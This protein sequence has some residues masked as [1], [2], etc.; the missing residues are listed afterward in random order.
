MIVSVNTPRGTWSLRLDH[1]A[2]TATVLSF[3][4]SAEH[5]S[6]LAKA[7]SWAKAEASLLTSGPLTDEQY[8]ARIAVCRACEHLNA[9]PA[10]LVGHCKVCGC[11]NNARA[12]LTVKGRMPAATCPK[13][14]WPALT[15][16]GGI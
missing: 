6:M 2:Q 8:E 11:N 13:G 5:Q 7:A 15:A 16:P 10:P 1:D 14:K 4:A 12:E 9:K 3:E